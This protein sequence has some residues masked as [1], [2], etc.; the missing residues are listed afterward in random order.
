MGLEWEWVRSSIRWAIEV[1][2]PSKETGKQDVGMLG[3]NLGHKCRERDARKEIDH[4]VL[5][6]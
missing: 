5:A 3:S 2:N 4:V 6:G 1:R